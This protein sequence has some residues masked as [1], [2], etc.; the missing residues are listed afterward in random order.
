MVWL[1]AGLPALTHTSFHHLLACGS[2]E[3]PA[4]LGRVRVLLAHPCRQVLRG[5]L[6]HWWGC[7]S[8]EAGSGSR[9]SYHA[10]PCPPAH[11]SSL[12]EN[13]PNAMLFFTQSERV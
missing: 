8:Q 10:P 12:L 2:G 4:H 7:D 11:R 1:G 6:C 9:N 13:V 5:C 3:P